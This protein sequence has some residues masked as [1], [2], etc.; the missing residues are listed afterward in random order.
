VVDAAIQLAHTLGLATIAEAVESKEQL[1]V[2][3]ELGC[4]SAQGFF[5]SPPRE[6]ASMQRL[7]RA[8]EGIKTKEESGQR[9]T[10]ITAPASTD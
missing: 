9:M 10:A 3:V 8:P 6:S 4:D 2:L 1:D 5:F 7:L